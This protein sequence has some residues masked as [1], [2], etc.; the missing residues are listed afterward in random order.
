MTHDMLGMPIGRF[1]YSMDASSTNLPPK[2][3]FWF[4]D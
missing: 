4:N 3:T 2:K 1:I